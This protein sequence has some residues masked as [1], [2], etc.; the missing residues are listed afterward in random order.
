M[1]SRVVT[2]FQHIEVSPL[3]TAPDA[4]DL[5]DVG[6]LVVHLV[7]CPHKVIITVV[8]KSHWGNQLEEKEKVQGG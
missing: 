4:V 5:C 7:Q 8:T 2:E 6:A 3:H 1:D